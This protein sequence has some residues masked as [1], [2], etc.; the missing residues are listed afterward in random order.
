VLDSLAQDRNLRRV[1]V[2]TVMKICLPKHWR[3]L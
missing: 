2:K 3:L 1:V